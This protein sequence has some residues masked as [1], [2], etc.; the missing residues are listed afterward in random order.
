MAT[1]ARTSS[2]LNHL[3]YIDHQKPPPNNAQYMNYTH[4]VAWSFSKGE[5]CN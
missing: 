1:D 4:T 2:Y 5:K 3:A